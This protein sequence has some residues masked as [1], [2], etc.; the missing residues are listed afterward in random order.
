MSI[1]SRI[2][3]R[4]LDQKVTFQTKTTTKS[5]TGAPVVVWNNYGTVSARVDA[6]KAAERYLAQ[7]EVTGNEYTIWIRWRGDLNT[8][9]RALWNGQ[10]LDLTGIPNNQ[11]RGRYMSVF[12]TAGINQG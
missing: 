12:A 1:L 9:M 6:I 8:N 7:Q 11:K 2:N 5:P 3:A 4:S 10:P